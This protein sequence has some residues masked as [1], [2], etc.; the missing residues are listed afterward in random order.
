MASARCW[1]VL[2]LLMSSCAKRTSLCAAELH[3]ICTEH[4]CNGFISETSCRSR[5]YVLALPS[6]RA[7][8]LRALLQPSGQ[9]FCCTSTRKKPLCS[10]RL[11]FQHSTLGSPKQHLQH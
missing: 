2:I 6:K 1:L 11:M 5:V 3:H 9:N 8:R 10:D 7:S 4:T